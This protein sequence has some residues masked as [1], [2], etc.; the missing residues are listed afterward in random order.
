MA[1]LFAGGMVS[2]FYGAQLVNRLSD[3]R[4]V[5]VIAVLLGRLGCC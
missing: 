2:A 5:L 3:R 1:G 4:L